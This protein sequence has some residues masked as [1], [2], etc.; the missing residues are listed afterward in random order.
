MEYGEPQCMA[1]QSASDSMKHGG[2]HVL[3]APP[4]TLQAHARAMTAE[5]QLVMMEK[6]F[7]ILKVR[8][9]LSP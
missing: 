8:H 4:H 5:L 9:L 6:D 1:H 3:P 7:A 2:P